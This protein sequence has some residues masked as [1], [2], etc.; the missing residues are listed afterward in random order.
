MPDPAHPSAETACSRSLP[1]RGKRLAVPSVTVPRCGHAAG[2][3]PARAIGR[4]DAMS[5]T[6]VL[7]LTARRHV[8]LGRVSSATCR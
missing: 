4:S 5:L 7:L 2:T 1:H 3:G 6:A 8:D